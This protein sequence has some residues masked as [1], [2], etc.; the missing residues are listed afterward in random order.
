MLASQPSRYRSAAPLCRQ[1]RK[2]CN[3]SQASAS[4]S[5]SAAT[6]ASAV[7]ILPGLG[8]AS[9]DYDELAAALSASLGGA[10]VVIASVA[11]VDWLRN[12]AGVVNIDYWRGTLC[13][14]PTVDWYLE[15][16]DAAVARALEASGG[17]PV[18]LLAHSAGG[19]LARVWLAQ[20]GNA[21]R[22]ATLLTLG[23]PL[24][25]PPSGVVDQTRGI[26]TWVDANCASAQELADSGVRVVCLAG[27][28]VRGS[29]AVSDPAAFLIG[30]AYRQVCGDSVCWGDGITPVDWALLPG[31]QHVT[32]EGCYHTPLGA[33]PERPWY[34]SAAL[35]PQWVGLLR[36]EAEAESKVEVEPLV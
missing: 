13:P 22:V 16:V 29:D 6:A 36:R 33:G 9:E 1:R 2:R 26:L 14:T 30:Q 12:A 5:A 31:A 19:W 21:A 3:C 11:R 20:P 8:N 10:A 28:F 17:A 27:R 4:S 34:G 7:V 35:L 18:Q 23:S 15:R 24:R 32:L 25:P